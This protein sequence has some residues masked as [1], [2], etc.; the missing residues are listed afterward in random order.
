MERTIAVINE[1]VSDNVIESYAIGGAV[2]ATF[3]LEPSATLD[4]DIFVSFASQGLLISMAPIYEYLRARGYQPGGEHVDI[5]GWPV[6]FLPTGNALQEEALRT[7]SETLLKNVP[8]RVMKPEYLAAIALETGRGKDHL[9]LKQ[10][11][12]EGAVDAKE[13]ERIIENHGLG[14]KWSSFAKRYLND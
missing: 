5:E 8:V 10:F 2:G 12:A 13:L 9:R 14:L 11:I 1:M 4:I 7:A 3:Y 6:Q